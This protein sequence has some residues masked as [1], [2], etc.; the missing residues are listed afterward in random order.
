MVKIMPIGLTGYRYTELSEKAKENAISDCIEFIYG[1]NHE[2]TVDEENEL[3]RELN[4]SFGDFFNSN[5]NLYHLEYVESDD[6][7]HVEKIKLCD[8]EEN[9]ISVRI[10]DE[11]ITD[12]EDNI[13][14]IGCE[15]VLRKNNK[16]Y[17]LKGFDSLKTVKIGRDGLRNDKSFK[18]NP[19]DLLVIK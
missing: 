4:L 1:D 13:L 15:V 12:S 10:I 9:K 8:K 5:G 18:C 3:L 16:K 6:K 17:M 11:R 14:S 2:L 19:K 7:L